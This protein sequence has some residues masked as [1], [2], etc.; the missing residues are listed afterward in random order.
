ME[1]FKNAK[2]T[3]HFL[4]VFE[5][6]SIGKSH[7]YREAIFFEKLRFQNVFSPP[8][9]KRKVGVSNFP[10]FEERFRKAPLFVMGYCER[11]T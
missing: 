9:R 5:E 4:F 11:L 7:D 1:E 8:S 2:I 10:R 6:D 3:D